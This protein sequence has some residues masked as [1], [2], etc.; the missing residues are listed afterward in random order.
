MS[1]ASLLSKS[2][3]PLLEQLF[4][5]DDLFR[6][7]TYVASLPQDPVE[8]ELMVKSETVMAGLEHFFSVFDYLGTRP[9]SPDTFLEWEGRFIEQTPTKMFSFN[10][11]FSVALTGERL[12][13]N[14]LQRACSIAT[15]TKKFVDIAKKYQIKILDTRKTT[16]GLRSLEKYAVVMGGGFNHRQGQTDAWMIKDNH[17]NFFGGL[18]EAVDFFNAQNSFYTPLIAEIHDRK[19]FELAL[20]LG[21]KHLLLDNF[22]P[23]ELK[24]LLAK[25]PPRMTIEISGGID[26]KNLEQF[27]IE[28]VDAIS[29]SK[30]THFPPPVDLSLKM[31]K[32][33]Q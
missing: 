22:K 19:E 29:T 4:A 16:P 17:K 24:N 26:L 2:M 30:L 14:I 15:Y 20:E 21:I 8:C 23:E 33:N 11:P 28:G 12:A 6:N 25:K 13:L 31:K 32:V 10:L 3:G 5:E 27:C 1:Q 9:F 7:Q 18:K